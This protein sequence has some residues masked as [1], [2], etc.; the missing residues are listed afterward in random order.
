LFAVALGKAPAYAKNEKLSVFLNGK[1]QRYY[2]DPKIAANV[3]ALRGYLQSHYD[4]QP[5]LNKTVALWASVHLPDLL[6]H[7]QRDKLA[8][9][10]LS[11]QRADGGWS[12]KDLGNW[13][14]VDNTPLQ[15][16]SDGYATGLV[17]LAL[18]ENGV[19]DPRVSHGLDWLADNQ[20]KTT[21]AWPAWS[22]NKQRDPNSNI[23]QFMSDAATSYAILALDARKEPAHRTPASE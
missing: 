23:G 3:A 10:L 5:L 17:V 16:S 20:D 18:E 1:A 7:V 13:E 6:T 4:A 14:R 2:E 9:E 15:D 22:L 8:T 21:G 19:T 11:R 12:L